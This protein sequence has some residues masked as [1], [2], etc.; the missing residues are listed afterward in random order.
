MTTSEP[1]PRREWRN[2][3]SAP[4]YQLRQMDG[5][6]RVESFWYDFDPKGERDQ[7]SAWATDLI[8]DEAEARAAL[9]RLQGDT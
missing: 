6:W 5:G 7:F 2:T 4:D 8:H 1:R 3:A 9:A